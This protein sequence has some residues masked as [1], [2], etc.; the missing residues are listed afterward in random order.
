MKITEIRITE[1]KGGY[2]IRAEGEDLDEALVDGLVVPRSSDAISK[3]RRLLLQMVPQE[4]V[5]YGG[6]KYTES[7]AEALDEAQKT[8]SG[9]LRKKPVELKEQDDVKLPG[10][11]GPRN[12]GEYPDHLQPVVPDSPSNRNELPPA[13]V[14][15]KR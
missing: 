11:K 3:L 10:S 8:M 7:E 4:L 9:A 13:G 2:R 12:I 15:R 5:D 14:T 6:R 1:Y